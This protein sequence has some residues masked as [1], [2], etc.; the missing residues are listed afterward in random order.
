MLS[1]KKHKEENGYNYSIETTK[2][3]ADDE[4]MKPD[5]HHIAFS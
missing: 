3:E 5:Q 4:I 1:Q 2:L